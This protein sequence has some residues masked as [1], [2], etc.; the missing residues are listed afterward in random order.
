MEIKYRDEL[1]TGD[2]LLFRHSTKQ[3]ILSWYEYIE[4]FL[5][6]IIGAATESPFTHVGIVVK[7]P[8]FIDKKG[9]YVLEST[10][11][12]LPDSEDDKIKLGVQLIP[13]EECF[14]N[15]YS[16][17]YW[18]KLD[19][20]R[21]E[22]F[23]KKFMEAHDIVH[24]KPYDLNPIDWIKAFFEIDLGDEQRTNTFWC[25]A[26]VSYIYVRFGFLDEKTPWTIMYPSQLSSTGIDALQFQNCNVENEKLIYRYNL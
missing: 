15:N 4:G 14:A 2:I 25:S 8:E 19:C 12:G 18:R 13:I 21:D 1:N 22:S 6:W 26:M 9:L 11:E 7:D 16:D 23:Y 24:N 10:Y 20:V 5:T 17:I 3:E